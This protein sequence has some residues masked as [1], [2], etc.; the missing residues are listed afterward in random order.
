MIN[1]KNQ[2]ISLSVILQFAILSG[3]GAWESNPKIRMWESGTTSSAGWKTNLG[4]PALGQIT[5]NEDFCT[6]KPCFDADYIESAYNAVSNLLA[7]ARPDINGDDSFDSHRPVLCA[8]TVNLNDYE[9]TTNFGRVIG[10]SMATA[11]TQHWR[12][13]VIKMTLRE[14]NIPIIPQNGEFLLSRE[15]RDLA[16][17]FDAGSVLVSSYSTAIDKVYVN[18][19]LIN[20]DQNAVVAATMYAIPL[21]PRTEAMLKNFEFA[22]EAPG[23]FNWGTSAVSSSFNSQT[24]RR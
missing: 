3:C 4:R 12:N 21:G 15:I 11:L 24:N 10:E 6:T 19:E 22:E 1:Y 16:K 13:K 20:V 5:V 14:N 17:S 8:S 7:T 18:V 2:I 23:I 9:K